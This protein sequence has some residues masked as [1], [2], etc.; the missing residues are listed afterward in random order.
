MTRQP[1]LKCGYMKYNI[2]YAHVI[3]DCEISNEFK[4][5]KTLIAKYFN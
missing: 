4:D 5:L 3:L 1:K 2:F